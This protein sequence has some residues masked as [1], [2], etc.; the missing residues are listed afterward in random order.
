MFNVV[1]NLYEDICVFNFYCLTEQQNLLPPKLLQIT[2]CWL[3]PGG[4]IQVTLCPG[5]VGLTQFIKCP[6]V[7]W[8]LHWITCINNVV[9]S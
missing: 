7:T 1:N 2:V 4:V 3:K 9:W 5:Q 8:I 6:G